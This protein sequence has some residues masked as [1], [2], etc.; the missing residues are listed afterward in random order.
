MKLYYLSPV[1]AKT[2]LSNFATLILSIVK[3]MVD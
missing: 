1:S 3:A 2:T